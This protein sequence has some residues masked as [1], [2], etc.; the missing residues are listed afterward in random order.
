MLL[1]HKDQTDI[2]T[3]GC[4]VWVGLIL[5]LYRIVLNL[6]YAHTIKV[7]WCTIA[8]TKVK[9]SIGVSPPDS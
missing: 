9:G 3:F 6:L 5:I 2:H 4:V 7:V 1:H 8:G